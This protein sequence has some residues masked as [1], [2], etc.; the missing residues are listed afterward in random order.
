MNLLINETDLKLLL[1][2]KRENINKDTQGIEV[3]FSGLAL[4]LPTICA[5]FRDLW[6]IPGVAIQTICIILGILFSTRGLYMMYSSHKNQYNHNDLYQDITKLNQV[7]HPYSIVAIKDTFNAHPNRFLLYYDEQ[8]KCKF[9]F[10]YKTMDDNEHNIRERLAN[11]LK[12][13]PGCIETEFRTEEIQRKYSKSHNEE[14]VYQHRLY[15]A[16]IE[17]YSELE[18]KDSFEIDGKKFYWMTIQEMERD[19]EIRNTNLDVVRLVKENIA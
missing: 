2:Q 15:Y 12:L 9:F 17:G 8:W 16:I 1:E 6:N 3:L 7:T 19:E 11:E 13:D 18:K 5:E 10:S 14:R 4:A